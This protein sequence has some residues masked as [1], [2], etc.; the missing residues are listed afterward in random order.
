MNQAERAKMLL[1]ERGCSTCVWRRRAHFPSARKPPW[2][3]PYCGRKFNV[4]VGHL[5]YPPDEPRTIEELNR[6]GLPASKM[7]KHYEE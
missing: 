6:C 5:S 1:T 7:C 2:I 4:R 3:R